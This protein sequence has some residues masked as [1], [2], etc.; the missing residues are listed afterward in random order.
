MKRMSIRLFLLFIFLVFLQVWLFNNI[1]LFGLATPLLYIYFLIKL[2]ISIN[3][4]SVLLLS[5]LLGLIIDIFGSTLGLNMLA[6]LITGFL[7]YYLLKLFAPRDTFDDNNP[8]FDTFGKFLFMRY[9][10]TITLIQITLLYL[11]ES[12]SLFNLGLLILRIAGSFV[13]TIL[14]IFA[15]ETIKFEVFR[16]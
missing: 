10:G 9:A 15:F 2:P 8:S 13:L 7:N 14:L 4:N 11:I 12:F 6:T 5:A 16:R 1:H 3:R